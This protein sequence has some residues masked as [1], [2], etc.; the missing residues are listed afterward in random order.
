MNRWT[1]QMRRFAEAVSEIGFANPFRTSQSK[2]LVEKA[3]KLGDDL[4]LGSETPQGDSRLSRVISRAGDVLDHLCQEKIEVAANDEEFR[5]YQDLVLFVSY[6]RFRDRF[7]ATIDQ[8]CSKPDDYAVSFYREFES[9]WKRCWNP[10]HVKRK[11]SYSCPHMFASLFMIRRAFHHIHEFI[12]G[13]SPEIETLRAQVWES[14][15]THDF[16]RF[17]LLLYDRMENVT[18]L[19]SGPSGSGKELVARAIG[20]SRYISFDPKSQTFREPF[21]GSFHPVNISALS[22]TLVES[23][24][25][26]HAKGAFTGATTARHGWFY[27]CRPGHS[28]FLDEIGELSPEIQVKL[29][30]VLQSREFQRIGETKV[31]SFHGK[32]IVA[33]NRDMAKEIQAGTFRE[34]LYYR[35]CS[36]VITTPSLKSQ[37]QSDPG[38]LLFFA[39]LFALK[40]I[41]DPQAAKEIASDTAE[42]VSRSLGP[43]YPWPGNFRELEQ[44]VWNV[45]IRKSY[46][47]LQAKQMQSDSLI[48]RLVRQQQA[49]AGDLV[50]AYCLEIYQKTGSYKAT[51]KIVELDQRTVKRN[52]ERAMNIQSGG[53]VSATIHT[54]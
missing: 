48:N 38:Q 10:S 25:F 47:P 15:F 6:Y 32:L 53:L 54:G 3:S 29:L 49:S 7:Q 39:E 45:M 5:L 36:D 52:V 4:A 41:S 42:W 22:P 2:T 28:V 30:R 16:R 17:G 14:I 37:L 23:E 35:I 27:K 51:A 34:D 8:S 11:S 33:S 1:T 21:G 44:C 26:G 18:T 12:W 20:M 43:N 40:Q 13:S 9:H 19:V 50:A 24:L 31:H 46:Q